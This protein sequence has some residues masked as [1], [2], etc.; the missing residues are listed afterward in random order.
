MKLLLYDLLCICF[1]CVLVS[2]ILVVGDDG[3]RGMTRFRPS[4][5]NKN[6][7]SK[8]T[9]SSSS[10]DNKPSTSSSTDDK[11]RFSIGLGVLAP[12]YSQNFGSNGKTKLDV[13]TKSDGSFSYSLSNL[14]HETQAISGSTSSGSPTPY[15]NIF[16][17]QGP[18]K[19]STSNQ[20]DQPF[21]PIANP[22]F[23]YPSASTT[24]AP[25]TR[26]P[27]D[28]PPGFS[29]YSYPYNPLVHDPY[30]QNPSPPPS[31][32]SSYSPSQASSSYS[33]IPSSYDIYSQPRDLWVNPFL[34][35]R[36]NYQQQASSNIDY[37]PQHNNHNYRNNNNQRQPTDYG[38][39]P[40]DLY[41]Q[42]SM[43]KGRAFPAVDDE[44]MGGGGYPGGGGGY[45]GGGF[46]GGG[47][48]GMMGGG[49]GM[50]DMMGSGSGYGSGYGYPSMDSSYGSGGFD[51]SSMGGGG[52]GMGGPMGGFGQQSTQSR[53]FSS[54]Y[55]DNPY[56]MEVPAE[57]MSGGGSPYGGGPN[58]MA[59]I[60]QNV[61]F[62]PD[63]GLR[64][65]SFGSPL[66]AG[67]GGGLFGG[68]AMS[69]MNRG[70]FGSAS[71]PLASILNPFR[72]GSRISPLFGR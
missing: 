49:G 4:Y 19:T 23:R 8:D 68:G 51:P 64:F 72:S 26:R 3:F 71:S 32:S 5:M 54:P 56:A 66:G 16:H 29:P 15:V 41:V 30:G 61:N 42:M 53:L 14:N 18:Q 1:S 36:V 69:G 57:M 20:Q 44:V 34:I 70:L 27:E 17:K 2:S 31:P 65:G 45:P 33:P 21:Q 50:G 12:S 55:E 59:S 13:D 11:P 52:G 58:P 24:P 10:T 47:M 46:G 25:T 48:P 6:D 39:T 9:L 62:S 37:Q 7:T 22:F 28:Y 35:P 60:A 67:G 40:I 43:A 38:R 63:G